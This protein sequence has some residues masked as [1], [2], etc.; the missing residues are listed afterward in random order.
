MANPVVH[1]EIMGGKEHDLQKFYGDLF[2]WSID[3]NNPMNYGVTDTGGG[4]INGG[5]GPGDDP[6]VTVYAAVDD[7]Q[8]FLDKAQ[9]LGAEVIMPVT[10]V[11]GGPTIAMF[12]DPGG[13]IT[14][15]VKGM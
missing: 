9:S 1:F 13:N 15:L 3:S 6:R 12:R 4:G 5:I 11:P 10:D 8:S 14:G 7:L 2:G